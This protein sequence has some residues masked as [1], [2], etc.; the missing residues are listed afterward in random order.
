MAITAGPD[1]ALWF[2]GIPGRD[3]PDHD[4]GYRDRVC[5][6]RGPATGRVIPGDSKQAGDR[7]RDRRRTGRRL[8]FTGVP[9][10]IGRITTTGQVTEFAVPLIPPAAGSAP[11]TAGTPA[12]LTAITAGPDGALWFTGVPGEIGRITTSG[13]VTE[14]AVPAI[15]PPAGSSSGTAPTQATLEDIAA[16]PDGALWFTGVPG[17]IGRI[18]TA[19]VVTEFAIPSAPPPAGSP[20]QGTGDPSQQ[21][22]IVGGPDGDL[23]FA[24]IDSSGYVSIGRITPSGAVSLFNVPGY[25]DAIA[26]LTSGPN[27]NVWFTEEEDGINAGEKPAVGEISP[28]G[29]TTLH[30]IPQGTTLDP[31]VGVDA[32]PEALT[33]GPGGAMWFTEDEA[34]GRI[35]P[36]GAIQRIPLPTLGATPVSLITG[37]G[38]TMWFTQEVT[39]GGEN[40]N[41]IWSIGR[42]TAGRKITV[43]PL[44]SQVTNVGGIT[45]GPDGNIWFT[46]T[47]ANSQAG[48]R[49]SPLRRITPMGNIQTFAL[50][51][52]VE[53]GA[54]AGNITVGPDGN[55]WFPISYNGYDAIG[56]I[57]AKVKVKIF[58]ILS[59]YNY[60]S[61]P[62]GPPSDLI[63]GPDRTLWFEGTVNGTTGIAR[64]STSGKL[65]PSSQSILPSTRTWYGYRM[66]RFGSSGMMATSA[67]PA[68]WGSSR[69]R[70]LWRRKTCRRR[71]ARTSK[72]LTRTRWRVD[73]A[74]TFGPRVVRTPFCGSAKRARSS[75]HWITG[76]AP[77][78]HQTTH[79]T[80]GP[81]SVEARRRPLLEW[82]SR[83]PR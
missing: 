43:Y 71:A 46:E 5:P 19:G 54:S 10:E 64:I 12:T 31:D 9:G 75:A 58:N 37:P 40:G 38:D 27:G 77:R 15:P 74:E 56:R 83:E 48:A 50:P 73:Q 79:T 3:R 1:G 8:W 63:S 51:Q 61:Y 28:A 26:G 82:R 59:T 13:V 21:P 18:T 44:P 14:L 80:N 6:A 62:P 42:I 29:V 81:M 52:Q 72:A 49:R 16:G 55:L 57:T 22:L 4:G 20:P 17:E 76:T 78:H 65:G 41:E 47:S 11:G 36:S 35:T 7:H 33:A 70:A 25:F 68:N 67:L 30:P 2:T 24:V 34:I 69:G 53:N 32:D 66:A 23:W 39:E 60:G 45:A